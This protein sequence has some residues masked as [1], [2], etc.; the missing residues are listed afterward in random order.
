M[1]QLSGTVTVLLLVTLPWVWGL[2]HRAIYRGQPGRVRRAL[3]G[4]F[5]V[6][7]FVAH[8]ALLGN[9]GWL[10]YQ[11]LVAGYTVSF[12]YP[13]YLLLLLLLPLLWSFSF[14]SLSG[15]GPWRRLAALTL[16]TLVL[17]LVISALAEMQWVRLSRNLTTIF[18]LDLSKSI[19]EQTRR[20]MV[21]YVNA[22]VA[23]YRHGDDRAGVIVF[24]RNAGIEVPPFNDTIKV[25]QVPETPIDGDFTNLEAAIKLALASFPEGTARRLVILSDGNQN[26]GDVLKQAQTAADTGIGIDVVPVEYQHRNEILVEKLAIP[27]RVRENEPFDLRVVVDNTGK[28]PVSGTL[29]LSQVIDGGEQI[30]NQG[31]EQ[32]K[33]TL[34]PGKNVFPFRHTIDHPNFYRFEA[35]FVPDNEADDPVRQNNRA[36][37]LTHV[38]GTARVLLLINEDRDG[39]ANFE[40]LLD[41]L[42][43]DAKLEVTVKT[44]GEAFHSLA[45]LQPYDT[46]VMA[47]TPKDQYS[48]E[49]IKWLVRNTHDTGSGLV[50][51]GGENSFGAGGWTN[52]EVEEAMPVYF[53]IKS[54]EV[55]PK[56]ALAMIMHA[57]E[58]ANGNFWQ[59]KVAQSAIEGLGS[60]DYCGVLHWNGNDQWLWN[61]PSGFLPVGPNRPRMLTKLDGMWP[62]DMPF[63]DPGMRQALRA[64]SALPDAAVK[65]MIVISDGDP[66]PPNTGTVTA[67]KNASITITTVAIGSHGLAGSNVMRDIARQTGGKYYNVTNP[68]NLPKIYQR[69]ARRVSKPL[70]YESKDNPFQ[71]YVVRSDNDMMK[72]FENAKQLPGITGYVMTTV[73]DN[74]LVEV[75]IL[76]PQPQ[77]AAVDANRTI[78]AHWQYGLGKSVAWTT[79]AGHKWANAWTGWE[80]YTKLFRQIIQFSMRPSGD[81]GNFTLNTEIKDGKVKMVIT[82]LDEK[83]EFLNDL[84]MLTMVIG[85]DGKSMPVKV[86]QVAPGRYEG[87]FD[88]EDEGSYIVAS[89]PGPGRTPLRAG[90][91]IP[92]SK[93]FSDREPNAALLTSLAA[94][95]A[96][97]IQGK[98][99]E[100]RGPNTPLENLLSV[101]P[102]RHDLPRASSSQDIWYLLV[103][104]A[105]Y[106][107]FVDV[108]N[109]RVTVTL[110][111]VPP[112]AA[113][114]WAYLRGKPAP[115]GPSEYLDRLRGRK[116]ELA[117]RLEKQRSAVR[118][119]VSDDEKEK[120]STAVR[121]ASSPA[122]SAPPLPR[123][124]SPGSVSPSSPKPEEESYTDRLLKAK[125]KVWEERKPPPGAPPESQS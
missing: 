110:A 54:S 9:A 76:S 79:D 73:K 87:S 28:V 102:F 88:A 123:P 100:A 104:L 37:A 14:R 60:Q 113:R 42:R 114:T 77:G 27:A 81:T 67:F 18:L 103:L 91:N 6:L 40:R 117:Q 47:D 63:F 80:N 62:G 23:K 53:H 106:L 105:G 22:T 70:I 12:N 121:D 125:R 38:A 92:Y 32:Q 29:V 1:G 71:P 109:R 115:A 45:E 90:V 97:G 30:L 59:K 94:L 55:V 99:I 83:E 24:G 96:K 101:D 43:K 120:Y 98:M 11:Q 111:W 124:T 16:R 108:F 31:A 8:A 34:Q 66:T 50:M 4:L 49:Q 5:H 48:D 51:L 46:V 19:P 75:S 15:L 36:T 10:I 116:A 118:F 58:M 112:L 2:G 72:G 20:D 78:L 65:H 84:P 21:T 57:S 89:S 74:P 68:N 69:E 44:P 95:K 107:F 86:Q 61:H 122:A 93:E 52:S 7:M 39:Q 119:E 33:V 85:P 35:R 13:W 3:G 17:L 82:A 26:R 41:V 64:F 56:G 25:A